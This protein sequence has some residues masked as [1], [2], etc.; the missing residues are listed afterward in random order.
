MKAG[1]TDYCAELIPLT[2]I[3]L[4]DLLRRRQ[5]LHGI[6]RKVVDMRTL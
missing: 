4:V 6:I 3:H 2:S 5:L 1:T